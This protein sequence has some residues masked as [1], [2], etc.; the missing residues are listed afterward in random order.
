M[1]QWALGVVWLP[2]IAG[3][4]VVAAVLVMLA[5]RDNVATAVIMVLGAG[6]LALMAVGSEAAK[7]SRRS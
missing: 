3:V 4:L 7:L 5:D 6:V 1:W 2:V